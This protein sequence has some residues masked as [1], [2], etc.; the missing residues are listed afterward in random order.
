MTKII[1]LTGGIG[2]GKTTVAAHFESLGIPVYIADD[3]GKKVLAYPEN[4]AAVRSIFGDEVIADGKINT[5][6]VAAIVFKDRN[7]LTALNN[8]VHPAVTSD[9]ASWLKR[10][11]G[12]PFVI[13]EAAVL[14]ESGSYINCDAVI[15]ITA[16]LEIRIQRVM[17]RDGI[18]QNE[19]M[20]RVNN[21]W[22]DAKKMMH[23]TF[24]IENVDISQMKQQVSNILKKMKNI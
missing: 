11:D 22:T 17:Q 5:K 3:A 7:K 16:P 14:F 18:T 1:G 9:F 15:L 19:V 10:Q 4:I 13:K 12:H 20:Q 21:Q 24:I 2:S 8:I 6:K 23:S